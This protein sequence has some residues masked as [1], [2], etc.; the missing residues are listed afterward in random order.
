[1]NDLRT[2]LRE[3]IER[4]QLDLPV[5]PRAAQE[6]LSLAAD[7]G[8]DL[9][10]VADVVRSDPTLTAHV[11]RVVNSP[12]F[13]ART[14]VVTLPQ[15]LARLGTV[16]VRQV[17]LVIACE[18][19]ALRV[20]G[21]EREAETWLAHAL[22]TAFFAQEIARVRR[23]S[24]EEGFLCGLLHDVGLPVLWQLVADLEAEGAIPRERSPREEQAALGELHARVGALVAGRWELPPRVVA[25]IREHH[26]PVVDGK[27]SGE[28]PVFARIALVLADALA[29]DGEEALARA[30]VRAAVEALELYP[31]ELECVVAS[32]RALA[33]AA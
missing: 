2:V 20:R 22:D 10:R 17:M 5:L 8:C 32:R 6:V 15:A 31:D 26:H 9:R 24:V 18:A 12:M 28:R 29:E 25:T 16:R 14:P 1:M 13:R 11:L 27:G 19:R 33:E 21:R 3:R 7:D 4:Q 23:Q 30:E